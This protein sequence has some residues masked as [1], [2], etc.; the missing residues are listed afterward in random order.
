MPAAKAS[1]SAAC[2]SR[3][4]PEGGREEGADEEEEVEEGDDGD[5][6]EVE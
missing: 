1:R 6:E 3:M 2:K 5:D 4:E